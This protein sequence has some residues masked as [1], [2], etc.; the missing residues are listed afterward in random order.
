VSS[1]SGLIWPFIAPLSRGFGG[2]H[3][4]IDIDGYCCPNAAIVAAHGG[5]VTFAGGGG[6]GYGLYVDIR[7]S[8]GLLTRYA[9]L[10]RIS[11]SQGQSVSGGQQIGI[12]GA[13]GNATG[14]HLHFEVRVGGSPVD[15]LGYLP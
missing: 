3:A 12:I 5:V 1:G 2:G 14:I 9:H 15:P 13:T 11:V 8:D 6:N 7:R 4:G 10:S